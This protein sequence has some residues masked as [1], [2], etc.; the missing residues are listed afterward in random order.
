VGE[1][2]VEVHGAALRLL[3]AYNEDVRQ[4][5]KALGEETEGDAL[6]RTGMVRARE[7]SAAVSVAHSD[8]SVAIGW[9]QERPLREGAVD[10]HG[11]DEA[12]TAIPAARSLRRAPPP[13]GRILFGC[14]GGRERG[15][16]FPSP[17]SAG[18]WEW[19]TGSAVPNDH[20]RVSW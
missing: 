19:E 9:L 7:Q 16:P 5:A 2:T 13:A 18:L 10:G 3:E 20:R 1:L 8:G 12:A 4:R 15:V 14:A 6:S 17:A 11:G